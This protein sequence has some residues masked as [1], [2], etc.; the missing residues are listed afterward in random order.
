MNAMYVWN[1]P[2]FL[3][4][5]ISLHACGIIQGMV[6]HEAHCS[7]GGRTTCHFCCV[8]TC[9]Y[10][11][12][13]AWRESP[14]LS[15][16]PDAHVASWRGQRVLLINNC[17]MDLNYVHAWVKMMHVMFQ[18]CSAHELCVWGTFGVQVAHLWGEQHRT[19][20]S[21]CIRF[22]LPLVCGGRKKSSISKFEL[23]T[24]KMTSLLGEITLIS[25]VKACKHF[26]HERCVGYK[27]RL[28]CWPGACGK[29]YDTTLLSQ[30]LVS[31]VDGGLRLGHE[32]Q[33]SWY[34]T[35]LA[36]C[37]CTCFGFLASWMLV[38]ALIS[39]SSRRLPGPS[40]LYTSLSAAILHNIG[41]KA[42]VADKGWCC[43]MCS[44]LP[45][46]YCVMDATFA[47]RWWLCKPWRN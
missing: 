43:S 12:L 28:Q 24:F 22:L 40:S 21:T 34:F 4:V 13:V 20:A 15:T 41:E 3:L 10:P 38:A 33:L 5:K 42:S 14:H 11:P 25:W 8:G 9:A 19:A 46:F 27:P 47:H 30:W 23:K 26:I 32:P 7:M 36:F 45:T 16:R 2:F 37:T 31:V 1:V 6:Q 44:A 29:A 18:Q 39:E 17:T 35:Y